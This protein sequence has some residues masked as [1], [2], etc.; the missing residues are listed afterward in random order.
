MEGVQGDGN[1]LLSVPFQDE[2]TDAHPDCISLLQIDENDDWGLRFYDCGMYYFLMSK[3]D[4]KN[5]RWDRV[6]GDLFFY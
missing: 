1:I 4:I 2:I 5:G 6:E 3:N